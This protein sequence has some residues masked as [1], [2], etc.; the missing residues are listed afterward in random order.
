MFFGC[1]NYPACT[2]TS[3]DRPTGRTC[4]VCGQMLV[5]K[6]ARRGAPT[7][8]VCSNKECEYKEAPKP[9]EVEQVGA[10]S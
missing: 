5:A 9:R 7:P 6:R 3:W 10:P 4:P 8:V 1:A 2:F